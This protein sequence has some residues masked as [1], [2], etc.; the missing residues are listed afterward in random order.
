MAA[1]TMPV[2]ID[3]AI[4][5]QRV[6]VLDVANGQ[7]RQVSPQNLHIYDYDWSPD[8]K[9]LDTTAAQGHGDN[10]W[11]IAKIYKI[12]VTNGKAKSFLK[13]SLKVAVHRRSCDGQPIAFI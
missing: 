6:A 12:N 2:V 1:P 4:H 13:S 9:T 10:N 7:L 11:W 5:S 3:T 8:D